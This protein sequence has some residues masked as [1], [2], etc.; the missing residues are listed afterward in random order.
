MRLFSIRQYPCHDSFRMLVLLQLSCGSDQSDVK[1]V[2]SGIF[3]LQPPDFMDDRIRFLVI[4]IIDGIF[5]LR[6][7]DFYYFFFYCFRDNAVVKLDC[8]LKYL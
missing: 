1:A 6:V 7:N 2:F 3:F 8:R 4:F 5:R